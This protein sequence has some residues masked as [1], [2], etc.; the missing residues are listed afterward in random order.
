M[1][2]SKLIGIFFILLFPII[3]ISQDLEEGLIAW[4]RLNHDLLDQSSFEI[5]GTGYNIEPFISL[6]GN[7]PVCYQ[8]NGEDAYVDLSSDD[9]GVVDQVSVSA[10]V[11]TTDDKRQF[12]VC[13]Y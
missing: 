2:T 11:K 8:F 3:L 1:E 6:D 7:D 13:K 9:R 5:E 4:Y 12:V 10:W